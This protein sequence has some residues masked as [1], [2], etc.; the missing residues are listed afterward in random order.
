[1]TE[2][3]VGRPKRSPDTEP[4]PRSIARA[5]KQVIVKRNKKAEQLEKLQKKRM[6]TAKKQETRA[7]QN[8]ALQLRMSGATYQEIATALGY[9]Q[10]AS[11]KWAVDMAISRTEREAA[12][13]VVA[14]DL[15][16]L[17]EYQMRCTH[18]LRTNGDLHQVDRLLRIM[19][20]RYRLLG[21]SNDTI[22]E[23]QAE[24]GILAAGTTINKNKVMI[25]QAAPETEDEFIKKMMRAVGINPDSPEAQEFV[26]QHAKN[27]HA[28]PMLEGSANS[29]R[30]KGMN[31]ASQIINEDEIV[32]AEIVDALDE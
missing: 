32:D 31:A 30:D 27:P 23:L 18:A 10:P 7:K 28:L 19:E 29:E 1:M 3:R 13:E 14:L 9:K 15:A 17:D 26:N 21:V 12:K 8:Q 24:H 25:V 5:K 4:Q 16:R 2:K 6:K 20:F 22:R 11:A